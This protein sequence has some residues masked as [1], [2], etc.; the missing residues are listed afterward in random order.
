M[1]L[2]YAPVSGVVIEDEF[3]IRE[4]AREVDRVAARH[5]LVVIAIRYQ[6]RMANA[7]QIG[8]GLM[9]PRAYRRQLS[10]E[11]GDRDRLI[12]ILGALFQSAEKVAGRAAAIE[13]LGK[14]EIVFR[15]LER[16]RAPYHVAELWT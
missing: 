13:G 2:K 3:G 8:R 7:R 10:D 11:G 15:V 6:H 1:V 14:E 12:A 16:Q 9:P 5:H 4:T